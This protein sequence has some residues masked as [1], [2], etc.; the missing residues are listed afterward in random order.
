MTDNHKLEKIAKRTRTFIR[1]PFLFKKCLASMIAPILHSTRYK[2]A[3]QGLMRVFPDSQ[4]EWR[5]KVSRAAAKQTLDNLMGIC[6]LNALNFQSDDGLQQI[7]EQAKQGKGGVILC[8]HTGIYDAVTWYLNQQGVP[9]QTIFGA[10]KDGKR[11]TENTIIEVVADELDIPFVERG[12]N[13][14]LGLVQ[15]IS[16]GNWIIFHMD[17]RSEGVAAEFFGFETQIP[18]TPFFIAQKLG[19][20]AYLHHTLSSKGTQTLSF[21]KLE[22]RDDLVGKARMEAEANMAMEYMEAVIR[23]NPE[24]WIWH[25]NRWK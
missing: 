12:N 17:L 24:Q 13:S 14:I 10:G 19:C 15:S 11:E 6:H 1:T 2:I 7:I 4:P 18:A 20:S 16:K 25:Y 22:P 23:E 21:A 9:T 5:K 3:N 8:P